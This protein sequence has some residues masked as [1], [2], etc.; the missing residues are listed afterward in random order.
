MQSSTYM[1][2]RVPRAFMPGT[3]DSGKDPVMLMFSLNVPIWRQSYKAAEI[4]ARA[5]ARKTRYQKTEVQNALIA[6]VER[7]LYDY[8]D[9]DVNGIIE[10]QRVTLSLEYTF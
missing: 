3:R 2:T 10:E 7:V 5:I 9:S 6:R 8:E 4:Q 1:G